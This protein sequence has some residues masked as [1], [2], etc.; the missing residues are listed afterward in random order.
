MCYLY[1]MRSSAGFLAAALLSLGPACSSGGGDLNGLAVNP[2]PPG[3][4]IARQNGE[5]T[6][7]ADDATL[8]ARGVVVAV[9]TYDETFDGKGVGD[10]F[11][12]DPK[13]VGDKGTPYSALRLY[14]PTKTPPD[15]QLVPG[16][17]VEIV[18]P[19]TAFKGPPGSTPFDAG[20]FSGQV[21]NGAITLVGEGAEPQPVELSADVLT[22]PKKA[23]PYFSR[24]VRIRDVAIVDVFTTTRP[25]APIFV[26]DRNGPKLSSKFFPVHDTK[27]LDVSKGKKLKSVVGVL[28]Y[29]YTV[30]LCPRSIADI[31]P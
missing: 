30:K 15:L 1:P 10:V 16:Q 31:E 2:Q 14:R 9:D 5:G 20:M 8:R 28:D 7:L 19:Y 29:F 17:W 24:L 12:Q 3:N 13:Q 25:E 23:L 18:G 22:D 6:R 11:I 27:G 26:S 21:A 4:D